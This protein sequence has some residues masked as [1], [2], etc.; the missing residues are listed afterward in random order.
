MEGFQ[1]RRNILKENFFKCIIPHFFD[2]FQRGKK[3]KKRKREG[4]KIE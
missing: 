4:E 1:R 2:H 3:E